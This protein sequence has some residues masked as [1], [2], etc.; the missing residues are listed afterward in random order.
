TKA[1]FYVF[2]FDSIHDS[3]TM[4]NFSTEV[5]RPYHTK[6]HWSVVK[7]KKWVRPIFSLGAHPFPRHITCL[8]SLGA[9]SSSV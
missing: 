2:V 3:A 4:H 6:P 7:K 8:N 9:Y 5:S 1:V